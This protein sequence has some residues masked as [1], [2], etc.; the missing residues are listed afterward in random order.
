MNNPRQ[1]ALI[2][3]IRVAQGVRQAAI[4]VRVEE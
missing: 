4:V 1:Q 3:I 2:S